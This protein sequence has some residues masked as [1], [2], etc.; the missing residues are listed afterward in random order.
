MWY[1]EAQCVEFLFDQFYKW[2]VLDRSWIIS[3]K[4]SK[5]C[6][7]TTIEKSGFKLEIVP[8]FDGYLAEIETN[9]EVDTKVT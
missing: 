1:G 3:E 7:E 6:G 5:N 4:T 9:G 8:P 2:I